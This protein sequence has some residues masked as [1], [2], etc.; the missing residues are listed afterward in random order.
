MGHFDTI[1]FIPSVQREQEVR[2]SRATY[3]K[4]TTRPAPESLGDDPR[5]FIETRNAF[6][7]A[8]VSETGWPYVQHRGGPRGFSKVLEPA[9]IG[10]A[11]YRGNRQ[12]V[13]T[14]HLSGD[15]R[16]SLF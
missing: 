2:G 14:G 13:S 9:H 1:V 5:Q 3:E 12:S 7:M 8:T 4:M 11:D 6:Y 16:V 10:F 15:D